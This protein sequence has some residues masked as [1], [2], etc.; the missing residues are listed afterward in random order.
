MKNN[1][2]ILKNSILFVCLMLLTMGCDL[3]VQDEFEFDADVN[4]Q[5]TFEEM[6]PW[7]WLQTNP[8]EEFYYLIQAIELTGLQAEFDVN[9][10][11]RTYFLLKDKGWIKW[12]GIV[13]RELGRDKDLAN[14]DVELLTNILKYNIITTY[15]D[16]GPDNLITVDK[17]YPFTTLYPGPE[18]NNIMTLSRDRNYTIQMNR[19]PDLSATVKGTN[20]KLH[21]YIFSN[22]TCVAHLYEDY[23]KNEPFQ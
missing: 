10:N 13:N 16:Q 2:K 3:E 17:D 9:T 7:E 12:N 21:N 11:G 23:V 5:I 8:D 1:I 15:V 14:A 22:G 20:V 19:S 6:T 18:G 4:P